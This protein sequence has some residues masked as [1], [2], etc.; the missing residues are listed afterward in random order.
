MINGI[1]CNWKM[2]ING[3]KWRKKKKKKKK[4]LLTFIAELISIGPFYISEAPVGALRHYFTGKGGE[5][6]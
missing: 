4:F 5:R 1:P 3:E 2:L 6:E